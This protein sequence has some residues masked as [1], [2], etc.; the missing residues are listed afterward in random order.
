M[1]DMVS[2]IKQKIAEV[3]EKLGNGEELTEEDFKNL[4][5]LSV[6]KEGKGE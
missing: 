4:F 6:L 2:M 3:D 5:I 1:S